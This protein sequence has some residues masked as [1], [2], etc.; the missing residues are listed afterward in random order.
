MLGSIADNPAMLA[1]YARNWCC[2]DSF[3]PG[4]GK[5]ILSSLPEAFHP[6]QDIIVLDASDSSGLLAGTERLCKELAK[7]EPILPFL[8]VS[9]EAIPPNSPNE[10]NEGISQAK[11]KLAAGVHTSLGG[12]L[13]NIGKRYLKY[14]RSVD[15]HLFVEV[16]RI[17]HADAISNP[18]KLGGP[19]GFDSD[20]R[21][22]EAINAWDVIEHDPSLSDKDRE[23]VLRMLACWLR[24]AMASEAMN[25]LGEQGVLHNHTTFATLGTL[26][27]WL[28]FGKYYPNLR[29]ITLWE[30]IIKH[31]FGRQSDS[32][33]VRDD[34]NG[35]AWLTWKHIALHALVTKDDAFFRSPILPH[36][37][38]S[39]IAT[40][41]NL[42]YTSP[43]GDTGNWNWNSG[44]DF[45]RMVYAATRNPQ[46]AFILAYRNSRKIDAYLQNGFF[47]SLPETIGK[48]S[49]PSVD[50]LPLDRKFHSTFSSAGSPF[51]ENGFDKCAF[52]DAFGINDFYLL[53]DGINVGGHGHEDA[54][55]ILRYSQYGRLWLADNDYFRKARK[56]H[57]TLMVLQNGESVKL[58]D[59]SLL[60]AKSTESWGNYAVMDNGP[61]QRIIIRFRQADGWALIDRVKATQSGRIRLT[62]RWNVIGEP[63]QTPEGIVF[64]QKGAKVR[65]CG[66]V[67]YPIVIKDD[68]E[69]GQNWGG[70][71]FAAPVVR[72]TDQIL[73]GEAKQ[74]SW[75]ILPCL[76]SSAETASFITRTPENTVLC[77]IGSHAWEIR[78]DGDGK[79]DVIPTA[80]NSPA[81][82]QH[83]AIE[84]AVT[85]EK[86]ASAILSEHQA[87][88]GDLFFYNAPENKKQFRLSFSGTQAT[89][90]NILASVAA[91]DVKAMNDG[92]WSGAG[93]S[94]MYNPEQKA[95]WKLEFDNK[96]PVSAVKLMTWWGTSSKG[97]TYNVDSFDVFADGNKVAHFSTADQSYP[98]FGAPEELLCRFDTIHAKSIMVTAVP[99]P[100]SALYTCELLIGTKAD[101]DLRS[102]GTYTAMAAGS[103]GVLT[104]TDGGILECLD[105]KGARKWHRKLPGRIGALCI[106]DNNDGRIYAG[107][108]DMLL[109]LD[110]N[111]QEIARRK[112]PANRSNSGE[113][114]VIKAADLNGDG[115]LEIIVGCSNWNAY[116][117]DAA[118]VQLW[119]FEV[120]HPCLALQT[121][122]IDGDGKPEVMCGTKWNWM[123]VLKP[124]G[125]ALWRVT[126]GPG[127]RAFALGKRNNRCV[128]LAA[129]A[130]NGCVA[131]F[132]PQGKKVRDF[133]TGDEVRCLLPAE[134]GKIWMGSLNSYLYRLDET[135]TIPEMK[136]FE[137]GITVIFPLKEGKIAVGTANG[138]LYQISND[139]RILQKDRLNAAVT[140]G[141]FA[142]GSLW[143]TLANGKLIQIKHKLT[144]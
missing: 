99:K 130:E 3:Y 68:T 81:F 92:S 57:N 74:G 54:N 96:L 62:Q 47:I 77:R 97:T 76:W 118:G 17:Y 24:D 58:N 125:S 65:L 39:Y 119:Q 38:H 107:C 136:Q 16:A 139:F 95:S 23:D 132:S 48:A 137:G 34:C 143:V 63:N 43:F 5:Y 55:S 14:R 87:S 69:L 131:F 83:R 10:F 42:G 15:A 133:D 78:F 20:F 59:Y 80:P 2:A 29:E 45:M 140:H 98:N 135:A 115:T 120:V 40:I 75:F 138:L 91:N 109:I 67:M 4:K 102:I 111:G 73:E 6:G 22:F 88:G 124:S 101:A 49:S 112:F 44:G 1:L 52:R 66:D 41:D 33:K 60:T 126:F 134:D 114:N 31:N 61:W 104:G 64:S 84:K 144:H 53:A 121:G 70:Y 28:Y 105:F 19:W 103:N 46:A 27:G 51:P 9:S 94:V 116:A 110:K 79:P 72:V 56:F 21:S 30:Q 11:A 36:V 82:S 71:P 13:A 128:Y 93:D 86:N 32:F 117:L 141:I 8:F 12:E 113:V 108:S 50:I 142:G 7:N 85:D 106:P 129:S 18:N 100:G 122:D 26:A 25:G 123:T 127:C 37:I 90:D 35:Y 89:G